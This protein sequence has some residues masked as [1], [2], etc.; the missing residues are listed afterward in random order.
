MAYTFGNISRDGLSLDIIR[1]TNISRNEGQMA[2]KAWPSDN[3]PAST[4]CGKGG[5]A[6]LLNCMEIDWGNAK[7]DTKIPDISDLSTANGSLRNIKSSFDVLRVLFWC[8]NKINNTEV[9]YVSSD[10]TTIAAQ[11]EVT[12]IFTASTNPELLNDISMSVINGSD[13]ITLN[14]SEPGKI[15]QVTA[16]NTDRFNLKYDGD[17][18]SR[19]IIGKT[20]LE[21]D[22]EI[23]VQIIPGQH[24]RITYGEP[25]TATIKI[26]AGKS[27]VLPNSTITFNIKE[28]N[29][30]EEY[31]IPSYAWSITSGYS[32]YITIQ[33]QNECCHVVCTNNSVEN[34]TVTLKCDITWPGYYVESISKE[35]T[36]KGKTEDTPQP[37]VRN[38]QISATSSS[39]TYNGTTQLTASYDDGTDISTTDLTWSIPSSDRN[40]IKFEN[41]SFQTSGSTVKLIGTNDYN[42]TTS[43]EVAHIMPERINDNLDSPLAYNAEGSIDVIIQPAYTKQS[44]DLH[45]VTISCADRD[46]RVVIKRISVGAYENYVYDMN[47]AEPQASERMSPLR[48]RCVPSIDEQN[49]IIKHH[50]IFV[51]ENTF[52]SS[53]QVTVSI[54]INDFNSPGSNMWTKSGEVECLPQQ[55]TKTY[56]WYVGH[57]NPFEMTS[58][59]P[60]SIDDTGA[61]WRTIGST[62]PTYSNTN[63]LWDGTQISTAVSKSTQ[64]VA[65]PSDQIKS[66]NSID[67]TDMTEDGWDIST[68]YKKLDG[69]D[70]TVWTSKDAKKSFS[71]T[72]Y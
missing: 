71:D 5:F 4:Y 33:P 42:A 26:N 54:G 2:Q 36:I 51:N 25:K 12:Q 10:K 55:S 34:K 72:L 50:W 68:E 65:L 48:A 49:N 6:N 21:H 57:T 60:L 52:D 66:R 8:Y 7:G 20:V 9:I 13:W 30:T 31:L 1:P 22:E 16:R 47:S 43:D 56:Y 29:P 27:S 15:W 41:G 46:G 14:N 53:K 63:P 24:I 28:P 40:Y 17:S 69:V 38:L 62:L 37:E 11:D 64:Y 32:S 67:G 70:Y 3:T 44:T 61:G 18:I 59:T 45:I 58:I 35:I 39:I 23:D 19:L